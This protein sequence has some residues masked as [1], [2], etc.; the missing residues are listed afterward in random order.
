VQHDGASPLG[1][2]SRLLAELESWVAAA[3]ADAAVD[4]RRRARGLAAQAAEEASLAGVLLDLAERDALVVVVTASAR[5]HRGAIVLV[6]RDLVVVATEPGGVALIRAGAIATVRTAPGSSPVT[7]DRTATL[8][9]GWAEALG[10]LAADRPRVR[11][12]LAG[13]ETCRG[14]LRSVG[15][16]VATVRLDG[17]GARAY[18][19]LDAIDD[20]VVDDV[21]MT[22]VF[23]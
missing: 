3:A 2:A 10:V 16:D 13:G 22:E 12:G 7:G 19:A 14:E 9:V 18:V 6:G 17:D 21:R 15:V 5:Q 11:I 1:G 20:V 4:D 23:G 8:S